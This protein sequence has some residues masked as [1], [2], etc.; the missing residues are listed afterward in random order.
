MES[1]LSGRK[2]HPA[3]VKSSE[4]GTVGSN[5]TDSALW[6]AP[7]YRWNK[8][9]A[10]GSS[11]LG[12]QLDGHILG[13]IYFNADNCAAFIA[14]AAQ[15]SRASRLSASALFAVNE[16]RR[17]GRSAENSSVLCPQIPAEPRRET[18]TR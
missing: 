5:P 2:R 3:K 6:I 4:R 7:A 13:T 15:P 1:W 14:S 16:P 18:L 17:F 12:K 9:N 11:F 8:R 10:G